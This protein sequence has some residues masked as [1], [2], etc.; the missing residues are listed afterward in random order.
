[1]GTSVS[2]LLHLP[3]SE[4]Q[5]FSAMGSRIGLNDVI[6]QRPCDGVDQTVTDPLSW[7]LSLSW[8]P[9]YQRDSEG[10]RMAAAAGEVQTYLY[11]KTQNSILLSPL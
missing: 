6:P 7:W 11:I 5:R 10:R 4:F 2:F 8:S 3:F 1:M 9:I